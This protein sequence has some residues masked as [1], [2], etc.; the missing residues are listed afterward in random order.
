MRARRGER[1][2]VV[3]EIALGGVIVK[4]ERI[5]IGLIGEGAAVADDD[6]KPPRLSTAVF[7]GADIRIRMRDAA[8]EAAT[9]CCQRKDEA[10]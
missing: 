4:I 10:Y 2:A 1:L 6:N 5:G 9:K 3:V 8:V 7:L